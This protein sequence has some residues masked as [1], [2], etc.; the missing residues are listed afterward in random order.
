M[1][2]KQATGVD[3]WAMMPVYG[4]IFVIICTIFLPWISIPVLKYSK[5]PTTYT[6]WNFDECIRNVQRSIQE[7]GRLKMDTFTG[8]ELE[9][10]QSIGQILK[11]AAVFLIVVMLVCGIVSYKMKK[12]GVVY[13]KIIFFISALYPVFIFL[14]IG[15]GN[16]FINGRMGRTSNFINL[17]I[18]SYIQMTSWQ[19]GQ[20][21]VSVLLFIFARKLLDTTAEKKQQM[22]IERSMKKDRRI[23]K[24][25]LVSLVLILAAIPFIIFFGIFFLNDRSDIFIS[26]CIIGLS[27]IPF[28]MVFEGRNPQAREILLI[29][30]MAAI[31]VVGRMAFF[32]VPQFKPVTAIVIIAGVGLGAEAGFLTGAMAGFVSNFFFGQGPWTPWQMFSFG[33]IGFLAGVIFQQEQKRKGSQKAE[34]FHVLTLCIFGGLATLIIYGF[35]MDTSTVFMASQ[36]LTWQ[37]F[38]AVYI[39]GFPFNVIH[40]VSTVIFLFFLALPMERKLDR[41]KKKYGILEA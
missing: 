10:L 26:M 37:S 13:V 28:C 27:M 36:E 32:M 14:L 22:Y 19:Y 2:K 8:Q 39:S 7:G 40:A 24:R 12:K 3:T 34:W 25:T 20:M 30:V 41:I 1:Q 16:L 6:F 11:I 21:I 17:T 29:A 15:A 35:L 9:M 18:H 38:L 31:A 33:I 5:L 23:G 4:S